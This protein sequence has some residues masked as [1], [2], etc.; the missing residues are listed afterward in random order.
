VNQTLL[1]VALAGSLFGLAPLVLPAAHGQAPQTVAQATVPSDLTALLAAPESEFRMVVS[2]YAIDRNTLD[3]NYY[4]DVGG[5]RGGGRGRGGRGGGQPAE[6]DAR[7]PERISLSPARIARLK[8]YDMEWQAALDALDSSAFSPMATADLTTLRETIATNLAALD[9]EARAMQTVLPLVPFATGL[10]DIYE[11]RIRMADMDAQRYAGVLDA[12]TREIAR[13]HAAVEAGLNGAGNGAIRVDPAMALRAADATVYLRTHVTAWFNHYNHYDPEFTWWMGM[14]YEAID[15]ALAGYA[16]LLSDRVAPANLT[17]ANIPAA[18]T[19]TIAPAPAPALGSVPA[20]A[21]SIALPQDEM[22]DVVAWFRNGGP[23]TGGGG[24]GRGGRGGGGGERDPQYYRDWLRALESLEFDAL[25]RNAQVDYLYIRHTSESALA[26][27]GFVPQENIPRKTDDSGIEGPAR[28]RDGLIIDLAEQMIPYTPEQLIE[29]GNREYVWTVEEMKK[30]SNEMGFGDDWMQA[31][32]HVKNTWVPPGRQPEIVRDM[33]FEAVDY[34]RAND[35]VTVPQVASESFHMTM[36]SPERQLT[37]P[38]FLGGSQILVAYP[39]DTM[40]YETR[41]QVLRG[42]NPAFSHAV[43]HH[44]MIP[45]HNLVGF[46]G[47]RYAAYRPSLGGTPFLGEGWPLY[48]E[49]ILYD[50]GFHDTPEERVGALFWRMHRAARIVFSMNFHMGIW[51]PADAIAFLVNEV[52]HEPDN[53]TAE[54][55][56]SFSGG[57]GPLYQMA[58]LVGGLQIRSIRAEIVDAGVMTEKAFHDEIMRQGSMPI[59]MLRLAL[60]PGPLTR[61]MDVNWKFYGEIDVQD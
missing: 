23:S 21:G 15:A 60:L 55:R 39:T 5:G 58:Y 8:R 47:S 28:G 3:D 43:A 52:G 1:R 14:P 53:A 38:F 35:V 61:D 42:N 7:T 48:W 18:D 41:M 36:L 54:V 33:L 57:Y 19:S 49:T 2:R 45:G 26:R 4:G 50:K 46:M 44:E 30:A 10:V 59:G 40:D 12:A 16:T 29:L 37:A 6:A 56:R 20:L 51:S 13:M 9:V 25:S 32:E 31:L 17:A 22:R 11:E 34:L 24:G 27:A